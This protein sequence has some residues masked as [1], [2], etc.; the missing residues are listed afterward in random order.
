MA[1]GSVVGRSVCIMMDG[2]R[3]ARQVGRSGDNLLLGMGQR[4]ARASDV[5]FSPSLPKQK[6]GWL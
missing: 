6:K 5:F 4:R 2:E 1:R 3:T